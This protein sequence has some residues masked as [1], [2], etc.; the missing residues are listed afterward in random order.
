MTLG[1]DLAVGADA[2]EDNDRLRLA[3]YP[4]GLP[5]PPVNA[6]FWMIDGLLGGKI[7]SEKVVRVD[8]LAWLPFACPPRPNGSLIGS[9][10]PTP[11]GIFCWRPS[12]LESL[13]DLVLSI[14]GRANESRKVGEVPYLPVTLNPVVVERGDGTAGKILLLYP[15]GVVLPEYDCCDLL[16]TSASLLFGYHS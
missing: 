15:R 8:D 10:G 5:L 16:D 6:L 3:G 7:S 9:V 12:P 13:E 14:P 2:P 4:K 11:V 1:R